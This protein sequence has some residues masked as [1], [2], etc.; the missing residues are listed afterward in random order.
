[1][2]DLCV[3]LSFTQHPLAKIFTLCKPTQKVAF[4]CWKPLDNQVNFNS[5]AQENGYIVEGHN[6]MS[7][8]H[9]YVVCVFKTQRV[10]LPVLSPGVTCS[11]QVSPSGS[12]KYLGQDVPDESPILPS[13]PLGVDKRFVNNCHRA[14]DVK[15]PS[16][17]QDQT[18]QR[19]SLAQISSQ[20]VKTHLCTRAL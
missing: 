16:I 7:K 5:S 6:K 11:V 14:T 19:L 15:T 10:R 20:F 17:W 18:N 4:L 2:H 3:S 12:H 13:F 1:M 8:S 9:F